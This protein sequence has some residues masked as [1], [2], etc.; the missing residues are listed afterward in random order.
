[1]CSSRQI[2]AKTLKMLH[3]IIQDT[4]GNKPEILQTQP[5]YYIIL[6]YV[7]YTTACTK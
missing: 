3:M 6:C 1:M 5:S 4:N 7:T 2:Y